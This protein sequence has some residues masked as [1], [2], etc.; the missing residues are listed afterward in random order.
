MS[1]Y[2]QAKSDMYKLESIIPLDDWLPVMDE[3]EE[4]M[5]DPT[6][7]RAGSMYEGAILLW[8]NENPVTIETKGI[9]DRWA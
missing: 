1:K 5:K 4:L 9:Y 2:E 3:F 6:K 7:K 8:F